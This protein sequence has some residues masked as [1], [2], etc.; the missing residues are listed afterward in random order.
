MMELIDLVVIRVV[1]RI[2]HFLFT[3]FA[4]FLSD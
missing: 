3:F 2:D 1:D 4:Q